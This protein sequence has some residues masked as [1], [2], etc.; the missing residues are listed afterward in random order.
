MSARHHKDKALSPGWHL[1]AKAVLLSAVFVGGAY[2]L[3]RPDDSAWS[4]NGPREGYYWSVAQY[5][6]AFYR[7]REL[8]RVE[9]A[10]EVID[11][12]HRH[13]RA[14]ILESKARILIGP[15][16]LTRY[17]TG[18]EGYSANVET[19][20]SFQRVVMR[21]LKSPDLDREGALGLLPYFESVEPVLVRLANEVRI[22]EMRSREEAVHALLQR[23]TL[24]WGVLTAAW[25]LTI[26]WLMTLA[27]SERK[28]RDAI[29]SKSNFL[30][31]V[32]HELRSPL[33][34]I[35]CSLDV[36]E[37]R[38]GGAAIEAFVG[39]IRRAADALGTQL[40][41]LLT[42]ATGE[43]GRL[44]I[45]PEA[46][47]AGDLVRDVVDTFKPVASAKGL[48]LRAD[49]PDDPVFVIADPKRLV[50]VLSNLVS[51]AVK[52]T[53]SGHVHVTLQAMPAAARELHLTVSDSGRGIAPERLPNLFLAGT[54]LASL[55]RGGREGVGIGLAIVRTVVEHLG[56]TV[57]VRSSLGAGS[58][59]E[60]RVPVTRVDE[61]TH[62]SP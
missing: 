61:G 21:R 49:V 30:A 33:Q 35:H 1:L 59:F 20:E 41:D 14:D 60:V 7:M 24:L 44:E 17:F 45:R 9:A 36:M 18:I 5:Q 22:E 48:A 3:Y 56:G 43:A 37:R 53:D 11:Q 38:M 58:S 27:R 42:L 26:A 12:D 52:Y 15:S 34:D 2:A 31:M 32:S 23:R 4:L 55:E 10:G 29:R 8:V 16:D 47:E 28:L 50:Q 19:L 46:F 62:A 25:L 40:R 54:R 13:L 6:L 51:N 57:D 39:R